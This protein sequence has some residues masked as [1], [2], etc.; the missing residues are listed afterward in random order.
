M[1]NQIELT[2]RRNIIDAFSISRIAWHGELEQQNFL[3]R[4][5]DLSKLESFDGRYRT[6]SEDIH[7]H[8]VLNDDWPQEWV[9]TD[10]R[11]NI[12]HLPDKQ[13]LEFLCMTIHPAVRNDQKELTTL[14]EIYQNNLARD[15]YTLINSNE[16]AT[17]PVFS[18]ALI[19]KATI[20]SM[21][22]ANQPPVIVPQ[23]NRQALVI[24][25][26][27]YDHSLPLTN[28]LND[29]NDME[30]KL[31]ELGFDVIKKN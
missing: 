3:G 31:K 9:F 21:S 30:S 16:I 17:K 15:G 29:A 5:F 8:T 26:S 7:K 18:P 19:G 27:I 6:A 22:S 4:L 20:S 25:C 28:P 2:T 23:E 12:L 14:L 11:F 1:S 24:G 13:F 10:S